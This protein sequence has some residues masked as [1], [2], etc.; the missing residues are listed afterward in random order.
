M[1]LDRIDHWEGL[2]RRQMLTWSPAPGPRDVKAVPA[3]TH[4]G[5]S[6]TTRG[7]DRQPFMALAVAMKGSTERWGLADKHCLR[8]E[9]VLVKVATKTAGQAPGVLPLFINYMARNPIGGGRDGSVSSGGHRHVRCGRRFCARHLSDAIAFAPGFALIGVPVRSPTSW[10][11]R[12]PARSRRSDRPA[13]P[14]I[15]GASAKSRR[16]RAIS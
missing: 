13:L 1:V 4:P 6:G 5:R 7:S 15:F 11:S 12:A 3:A 2:R 10:I 14:T 16:R 8:G 9:E